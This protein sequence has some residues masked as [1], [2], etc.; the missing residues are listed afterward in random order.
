MRS[1]HAQA[2]THPVVE[3]K[4]ARADAGIAHN[5]KAHH[6]DKHARHDNHAKAAKPA[7]GTKP[8]K[9]AKVAKV[10]S[11]PR[12]FL[13]AAIKSPRQVGAVIP[14]SRFL[15]R[16]MMRLAD[17]DSARTV[18]EY[19][20]GTG[21][22]TNEIVRVLHP[23]AKFFAIELN[24]TMAQVFTRNHPELKLHV[25]SV[26]DVEQL[27]R[28]EKLPPASV[29]V[30]ISGLPWSVLP[31]SLQTELLGATIRVL[32]PGGVM[33]TYGY[34]GGLLL[35]AGRKFSRSLPRFFSKVTRS[36]PVWL[37]LPPAFIYRCEK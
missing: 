20:P 36:K 35:K 32:R 22:I 33:L 13:A 15:G 1:T 21:T 16:A 5:G 9:V 10:Q 31:E 29:D 26:A 6:G 24:E 27:C 12:R 4:S 37:N 28:D 11:A 14:S 18:I 30:I 25:R 34:H 8:L 19:G 7:K 3:S 17:M 23:E 2:G